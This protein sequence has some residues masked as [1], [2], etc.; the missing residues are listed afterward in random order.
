MNILLI[1]FNTALDMYKFI[2]VY[3]MATI[4]IAITKFLKN[5]GEF[6]SKPGFQN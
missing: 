4:A 3:N 2:S 5:G 1:L 6:L